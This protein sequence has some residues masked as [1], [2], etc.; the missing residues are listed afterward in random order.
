MAGRPTKYTQEVVNIIRESLAQGDSRQLACKKAG[1]SDD[2]FLNWMRDN[3]EFSAVVKNAEDEFRNWEHNEILASAKKSLRVL[4]E[5]QEYDETITEYEN[6][7]NGQPRIKRQTTKTKKVLP[8][9]TAVIF[10]L[11]N[12]DPDNWKNRIN[13]EVEAK[14]QSD[15]RADVN[16]KNIPD[17][18]LE[19]VI[20]AI[21][22]EQ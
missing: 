6:D 21:N 20:K 1:I 3:S 14:V 18:L 7:G 8:S 5:G 19:Q 13:S 4:I 2:S 12:R 10:A 15:Q 22:G 17:D 9:A 16:M 11:V